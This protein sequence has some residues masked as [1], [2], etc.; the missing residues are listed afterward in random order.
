MTLDAT[1]PRRT[2]AVAGVAAAEP[3][4][5]REPVVQ[6]PSHC[7][8]RG[9][10]APRTE[11]VTEALEPRGRNRSGLGRK[12]KAEGAAT[13]IPD[14]LARSLQRAPAT[15]SPCLSLQCQTANRREACVLVVAM[16]ARRAALLVAVL[17][18]NQA[19]SSLAG[20]GP[21]SVRIGFQIPTLYRGFFFS[22]SWNSLCSL[23]ARSLVAY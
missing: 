21:G 7:H 1:S 10:C 9:P 17:L 6:G 3:G 23:H 5:K 20:Y 2:R 13:G 11:D 4:Q 12:T 22:C 14:P 18:L 16:A 15:L 8:A 19:V